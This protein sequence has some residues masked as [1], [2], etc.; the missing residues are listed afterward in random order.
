MPP[1][2][3]DERYDNER[4]L[5]RQHWAAK[6][7]FRSLQLV[8]RINIDCTAGLMAP[9]GPRQQ[10][11]ANHRRT[12]PRKHSAPRARAAR[13][14]RFVVRDRADGVA[15]LQRMAARP[16]IQADVPT[17]VMARPET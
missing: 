11:Q 15:K 2:L 17:P 10:Q 3:N 1:D 8:L 7:K 12:I 6:F 14:L 5:G 16:I 4:P 9:Y 13:F